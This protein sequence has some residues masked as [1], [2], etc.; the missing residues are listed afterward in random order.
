MVLRI[1]AQEGRVLV[2]HD[3]STI[4]GHLREFVGQHDSPGVIL[5]PQALAIGKAIESLLVVCHACDCRDL[6]NR[7]CLIPSL[8]MY[9]F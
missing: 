3:V 5:I 2:S 8:A 1:A 7:V 9:G 4:P 6:K